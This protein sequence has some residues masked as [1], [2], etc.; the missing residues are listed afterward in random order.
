MIGAWIGEEYQYKYT[1]SPREYKI[2]DQDLELWF[3]WSPCSG[4]TDHWSLIT[5]DY[6]GDHLY[7]YGES[8]DH[9]ENILSD[10]KIPQS[11][12]RRKSL[13]HYG[14]I[15]L[16]RVFISLPPHPSRP[17]L[18]EREFSQAVL[19]SYLSLSCLEWE[20]PRELLLHRSQLIPP[21][22]LGFE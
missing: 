3:P 12:R 14:N 22:V 1:L 10:I 21:P 15:S 11:D 7:H 6:Y 13:D 8:L 19:V 18:V 5:L 9:Y 20:V 16:W 2:L 4:F 17:A